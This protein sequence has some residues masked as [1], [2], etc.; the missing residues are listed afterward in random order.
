MNNNNNNEEEKVQIPYWVVE[1]IDDYSNKHLTPIKDMVD[2]KYLQNN[3][4]AT[5]I[6]TIS[7]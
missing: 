3:Y 2:L 5:I 4:H 7:A 6:E 1:Y